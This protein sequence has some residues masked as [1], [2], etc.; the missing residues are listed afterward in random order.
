MREQTTKDKLKAVG[1]WLFQNKDALRKDNLSV[2]YSVLCALDDGGAHVFGVHITN[3]DNLW[4]ML[5]D[6]LKEFYTDHDDCDSFADYM[7][8]FMEHCLAWFD[9]EEEDDVDV[10]SISMTYH[11]DETDE[12]LGEFFDSAE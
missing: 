6:V 4:L 5:Y 10:E 8:D 2:Q 9:A 11:P 3:E 1:T 7:N 12:E